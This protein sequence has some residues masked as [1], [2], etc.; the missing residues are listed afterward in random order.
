MLIDPLSILPKP[1]ILAGLAYAGVTY[2]G[3]APII[4]ERSTR[5]AEA[6]CVAGIHTEA[7]EI[8]SLMPDLPP[9]PDLSTV[10]EGAN[11]I[12]MNPGSALILDMLEQTEIPIFGEIMKRTIEAQSAIEAARAR[13]RAAAESEA[14]EAALDAKKRALLASLPDDPG[15][16]CGCLRRTAIA[17]TASSWAVHVGSYRLWSDPNV[18]DIAG[19]MS[20]LKAKGVCND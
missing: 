18:D 16:H 20:N 19:V 15:T 1:V 9:V 17:E 14:A 3:T 2:F 10:T 6:Q 11:D 5:D 13:A 7:R 12:P 8:E 4:A